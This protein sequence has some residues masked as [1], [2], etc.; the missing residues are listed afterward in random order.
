MQ[1]LIVLVQIFF[2]SLFLGI[3]LNFGLANDK[4]DVN[5]TF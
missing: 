3:T 4:N 2:D 1:F 5:V